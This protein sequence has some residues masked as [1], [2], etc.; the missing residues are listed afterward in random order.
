MENII[1]QIV[2]EYAKIILG[3][4]EKFGLHDL[5]E[6]AEELKRISGGMALEILRAFIEAADKAICEAKGERRGDGVRIRESSVP[7]ELF[8]ALG[9]FKYSRTYFDTPHGREYILDGMLGVEAYERVDRG[10]S[11]A[12]VNA[13]ASNSYGRSAEI[14]T[15]GKVSRQSAR[16]KAINTGEVAYV[17]ERSANAPVA[18]HIFADEDHVSLQDGKGAILPLVT[19]CEGKR[20]VCEGRN[21]LI[22]PFH[23]H[24]YGQDPED[25]WGYVYALCEKKYDM[26][27][28]KEIYIYGDGAPW[29]QKAFEVFPYAVHVLDGFHYKK[30]MKSL[31]AGDIC[32]AYSQPLHGA[33]A[34]GDKALFDKTVQKML[35]EVEAEMAPGKEKDGRVKNIAENNAYFQAHW[36]AVMNMKLEGSIGSCTEAM[37]SHVLSQRFSR[38]PMGWSKEGLSKMA[39]IRVYVCNG[40]KVEPADTTAWKRKSDKNSVIAKYDKYEALVKEQQDKILKGAKNWRWFEAENLISGKLTGTK[41]ALDALGQTRKI[42]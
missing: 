18:L 35:G 34:R 22:E 38:S 17:P 31:L 29:I 5:S 39:M 23:V 42:S 36:G 30:R 14:V 9:E 2:I 11:A 1:L 13:A 6:M 15:G 26:G 27:L 3:Y 20:P 41:A 19:V 32:R 4:H 21:E 7:R 37:V 28:V 33:V 40:G 16:N 8:T 24:G 12:L 10:V 25:L